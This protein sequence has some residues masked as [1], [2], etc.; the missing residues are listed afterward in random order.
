[1]QKALEGAITLVYSL[2]CTCDS[3]AFDLWFAL[4]LLLAACK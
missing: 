4:E 1:M 2:R 3:W